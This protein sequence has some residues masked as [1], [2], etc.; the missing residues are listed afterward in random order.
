MDYKNFVRKFGLIGITNFLVTISSIILLPI[1]TKNLSIIDYSIWVQFSVSISLVPPLVLLGLHYA[2]M[3]FVPQLKKKND[4]RDGLYSIVTFVFFISVVLAIFV[5]FGASFL[6]TLLFAG[7]EMVAKL[8]ALALILVGLNSI[9]LYYFISFQKIKIYSFLL[10][11]QTYLGIILVSYLILSGS[12]ITN[13]IIGFL[14]PF[15]IVSV[16]ILFLIVIDFGLQIPNFKFMKRYLR[17]AL[18]I[19]PSDISFWVVDSIDRYMIG[20]L[21]G[22][23]FVA[24]YSPSYTLGKML[25]LIL[26]PLS[27]LLPPV[28]SKYYENDQIKDVNLILGFSIKYFLLIGIPFIIIL[29]ILS[30]PILIIFATTEIATNGYMVT[31]IVTLGIMFFG[32]YSIM[33]NIL[34]LEMNTKFLSILWIMCA[35]LN[36]IL[37]F[38]LVPTC[39]IIGAA[40]ATLVTYGTSLTIIVYLSRHFEIFFNKIFVMKCLISSIPLIIFLLL[41]KPQEGLNLIIAVIISSIIYLAVLF[42][43][44]GFSKE[45]IRFM[46]DFFIN[47]DKK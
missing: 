32:L 29:S 4:I 19:I 13:A 9:L 37:N 47:S 16:I 36:L 11:F 2:L 10:L 28:L 1:L 17:F 25:L 8:L 39:G 43:L 5:Y 12:G 6:S 31:P 44:D 41:L 21:L 15:L 42:S 35:M 30:K 27:V 18:P 23:S 7:N 46:K 38:I 3:R 24:Y 22:T 33:S 26:A 45:E 40:L 14:I 34:I 20:V